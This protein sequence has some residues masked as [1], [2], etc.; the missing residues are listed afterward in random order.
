MLE[1]QLYLKLFSNL[2][3]PVLGFWWWGW[4]LY[5][6]LLFYFLDL[7]SNELVVHLKVKKIKSVQQ[8]TNP[9]PTKTM[10]LVSFL[11]LVLS[12]VVINIGMVIYHPELSLKQ[13]IVNFIGYK[14]MGLEQG[15][16]LIP[17]I[18]LMTFAN[19]KSDFLVPKMFLIQREK[20]VWKAHIKQHFL[21]ISFS[22]I[23]LLIAV[24]YQLS[25]WVILVVILL[26]TTIYH[27]LQ[28]KEHICT[29]QAFYSNNR[30]N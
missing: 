18:V 29:I 27:F 10:A 9:T 20:E 22:A 17:L 14:E 5:F 4:S 11:F 2:I 12:I 19:Y 25:E 24:S 6:I 28:G 7:F 16:V 3:I 15:Y 8:E 30:T 21:L 13:E 26:L 23:L 1:R